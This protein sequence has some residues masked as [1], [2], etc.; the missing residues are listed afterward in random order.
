MTMMDW[1]TIVEKLSFLILDT[2]T[3]F[4]L[5]KSIVQYTF[6]VK[7]FLVLVERDNQGL[8]DAAV[9]RMYRI[10]LNVELE[11]QVIEKELV[12]DLIDIYSTIGALPMEK[13]EGL[14]YTKKGV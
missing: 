5:S 11:G 4:R 12:T 2:S 14:A 1:M 13:I 3:K 9:K 10:D 7:Y 6:H 8:T